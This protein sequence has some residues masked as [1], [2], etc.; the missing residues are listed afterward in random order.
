MVT[1]EVC[2]F[3]QM[4]SIPYL[5]QIISTP[6]GPPGATVIRRNSGIENDA[7]SRVTKGISIRRSTQHALFINHPHV[8]EFGRYAQWQT[9]LLLAIV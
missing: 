8:P 5:H 9:P 6:A 2:K 7:G 3:N 1:T 4:H